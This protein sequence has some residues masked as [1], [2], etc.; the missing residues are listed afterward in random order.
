MP[1]APLPFVRAEVVAVSRRLHEN[2]WVANHDGNISVRLHGDRLLITPT[3]YS[4]RDVDDAALIIVDFDGKV[5]EG[6]KKP[7][8]ELELHLAIY[9]ARPDVGAIARGQPEATLA[10][11][12]DHDELAPLHGQAAWLGRRIPVHPVPRLLRTAELAAAA[13]S[14]LGEAEAMVLRGNGAV[15]TGT[16]PGT[17]VARMHLLAATCRVHATVRHPVPLDEDDI[18]AWRTAAP[19]LLTRLWLHLARTHPGDNP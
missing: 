5:L 7:F 6:R 12:A 10:V 16:D 18:T 9:R 1:V 11:G 8:S 14:T 13:A 15:T 19:P 2:G 3:A 4:K 17:A